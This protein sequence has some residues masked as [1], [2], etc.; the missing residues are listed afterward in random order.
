MDSILSAG[1]KEQNN[2]IKVKYKK[3]VLIKSY[4]TEVFEAESEICIDKP[5]TGIERIFIQNILEAQLEYGIFANLLSKGMITQHE[6]AQRKETLESEIEAIKEKA[7]TLLGKG[8]I[9]EY[10]DTQV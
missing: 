2:V 10:L 6:F 1:L 4:E 8:K 9:D 3:T 5:I 7:D